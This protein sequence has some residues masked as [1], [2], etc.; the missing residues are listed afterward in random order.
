MCQAVFEWSFLKFSSPNHQTCSIWY[1][2]WLVQLSDW[3]AVL[4][5]R[6]KGFCSTWFSGFCMIH[7]AWLCPCWC[8]FSTLFTWWAF[9][10]YDHFNSQSRRYGAMPYHHASL[11]YRD[12]DEEDDDDDG[13]GDGDV[14]VLMIWTLISCIHGRHVLMNYD[15][16][17]IFWF[18][19]VWSMLKYS[20]IKPLSLFWPDGGGEDDVVDDDSVCRW[21][22]W[23]W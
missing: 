15:T 19:H 10:I 23:F 14:W 20:L 5:F 8:I 6:R 12:E 3:K 18:V 22:W 11:D 7:D 21:L 9:I 1:R 2:S 4:G 17:I 13:D 16:S